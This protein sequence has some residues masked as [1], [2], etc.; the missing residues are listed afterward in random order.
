MSTI[1]SVITHFPLMNCN[2]DLMLA[3]VHVIP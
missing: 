3:V 1:I 2:G